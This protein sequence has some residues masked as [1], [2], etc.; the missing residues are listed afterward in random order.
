LG[1]VVAVVGLEREAAV[2]RG[3][4]VVTVAG[5]GEPERMR[6]ERADAA[7]GSAGIISFGMAGA[8]DPELRIG[9]WVIGERVGKLAC[10]PAWREALSQ[11]LPGAR[12]GPVHADGTLI[13]DPDT[14]MNLNR[15]SGCLAADMESHVAAQVAAGRGVPFAVLRCISDE[16]GALLPPAIAVAMKPGGGLALGAVLRSIVRAPGQVPHLCQTVIG[17]NRAY[18]ELGRGAAALCPPPAWAST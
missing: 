8:L 13:T 16:A 5:G 2:L 17:F 15:D 14:K 1:H 3:L 9:D 6:R 11:R 7:K 10:D 18:G 4:E 12:V